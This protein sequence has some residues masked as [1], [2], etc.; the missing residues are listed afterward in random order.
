MTAFFFGIP[1]ALNKII[2]KDIKPLM[3]QGAQTM[4]LMASALL[5]VSCLSACSSMGNADQAAPKKIPL[6]EQEVTKTG[7][8]SAHATV[9][10]YRQGAEGSEKIGNPAYPPVNLYI[11]GDYHAS[12]RP[13]SQ[14]ELTVC[15]GSQRLYPL[16]DNTATAL[17]S[18]K[19]K[20]V[21]YDL[22]PGSKQYFR[23]MSSAG[24]VATLEPVKTEDAQRELASPSRQVY[25]ISRFHVQKVCGQ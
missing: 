25:T 11:N 16:L 6:H 21:V 17:L 23:V 24:A 4:R 2:K 3:A 12:L 20:G 18:K 22:K 15:A 10:V 13:M 19:D 7:T 1:L 9:V 14:I 5:V 8:S